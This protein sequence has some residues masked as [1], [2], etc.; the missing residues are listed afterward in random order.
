MECE[1]RQLTGRKSYKLHVSMNEHKAKQMR[2]TTDKYSHIQSCWWTTEWK[3]FNCILSSPQHVFVSTT[4]PWK[5]TGSVHITRRLPCLQLTMEELSTQNRMLLRMFTRGKCMHCVFLYLLTYY[6]T[7][8]QRKN[9]SI[10]LPAHVA[11]IFD[12]KKPS[13]R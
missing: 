5:D 1:S 9:W 2:A 3:L 12:N 4:T 8:M 13:C 10:N 6:N 7:H 11:R